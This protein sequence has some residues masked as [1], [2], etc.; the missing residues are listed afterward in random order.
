MSADRDV[1]VEVSPQALVGARSREL[2]GSGGAHAAQ[3][4]DDLVEERTAPLRRDPGRNV[5]GDREA[6]GEDDQAYRVAAV[7]RRRE[8]AAAYAPE[9]PQ[10]LYEPALGRSAM[11]HVLL[12]QRERGRAITWIERRAVAVVERLRVGRGHHRRAEVPA[13]PPR[14][15]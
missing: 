2:G 7:E 9:V 1:R 8:R 15:A 5:H 11:A 6:A 10:S 13:E 12:V 14:S 4:R 3:S